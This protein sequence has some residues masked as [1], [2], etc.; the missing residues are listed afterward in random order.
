LSSLSTFP[1]PSP[2]ALF[3]ATMWAG[4]LA[5]AGERRAAGH[6]EAAGRKALGQHSLR[7]PVRRGGTRCPCGQQRMQAVMTMILLGRGV[8]EAVTTPAGE[9]RGAGRLEEFTASPR[10]LRAAPPEAHPTFGRSQ[11]PTNFILEALGV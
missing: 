8:G 4:D 6:E 10:T 9:M 1:A 7:M 5:S 11:L 3:A 2:A